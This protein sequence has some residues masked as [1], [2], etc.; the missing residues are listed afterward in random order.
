MGAEFPGWRRASF[1]QSLVCFLSPGPLSSRL[2]ALL[3]GTAGGDQKVRYVID[4]N[5]LEG[6]FT[7]QL[8]KQTLSL[9]AAEVIL[10]HGLGVKKAHGGGK[11]VFLL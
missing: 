6:N 9:G 2:V 11:H 7:L 5:A 8:G 10:L 1:S 3:E 4:E